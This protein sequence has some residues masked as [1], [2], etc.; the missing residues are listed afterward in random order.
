MSDPHPTP[1]HPKPRRAEPLQPDRP[2]RGNDTES[3][4]AE[5]EEG[6][7]AESVERRKEQSDAALSNVREGYGGPGS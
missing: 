5:T 3:A 1:G 7:A 6:A 2:A 4:G